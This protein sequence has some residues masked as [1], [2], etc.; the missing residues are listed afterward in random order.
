V[1]TT[2]DD[3]DDE[4]V[5]V[6]ARV[7]WRVLFSAVAPLEKT[8]FSNRKLPVGY[9]ACSNGEVWCKRSPLCA[10]HPQ[11]FICLPAVRQSIQAYGQPLEPSKNL[12]KQAKNIASV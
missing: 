8:I 4:V 7:W 9:N 5:H 6:Y 1:T 3:D 2:H 11:Q 10:P 12:Q